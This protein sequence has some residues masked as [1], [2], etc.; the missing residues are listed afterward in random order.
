MDSWTDPAKSATGYA[1]EI[2]NALYSLR[3]T[4][5]SPAITMQGRAVGIVTVATPLTTLPRKDCQSKH[6]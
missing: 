1:L 5:T 3:P 4:F 6:P 2:P